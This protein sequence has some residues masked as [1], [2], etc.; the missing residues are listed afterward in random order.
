MET[1]VLITVKMK[2]LTLSSIPSND[3]TRPDSTDPLNYLQDQCSPQMTARDL[4]LTHYFTYED[5]NLRQTCRRQKL[6]LLPKKDRWHDALSSRG[7]RKSSV[8]AAGSRRRLMLRCAQ[9]RQRQRSRPSMRC[10]QLRAT[11]D[12]WP[13]TGAHRTVTDGEARSSFISLF[14]LQCRSIISRVL[15][16][17][18]NRAVHAQPRCSQAAPPPPPPLLQW[19]R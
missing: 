7:D 17:P 12:L 4:W 11:S 10:N 15:T 14:Q 8:R 19:W 5:I 3:K 2:P 16:L 13:P 9:R 6:I 18:K 1:C